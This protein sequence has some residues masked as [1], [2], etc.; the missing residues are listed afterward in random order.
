M[1]RALSAFHHL[2]QILRNALEANH[3][4]AEEE[5]FLLRA[6]TMDDRMLAERAAQ[7]TA[8]LKGCVSVLPP[9]SRH[10]DYD[11]IP[12]NISDGCL[13]HCAFCR[14]KSNRGFH[15]RSSQDILEQLTKLKD[16]YGRTFAIT[17]AFI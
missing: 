15:V 8:L 11:C 4:S 12:L 1:Q 14:V 3:W 17:T 7:L 2:S 9:D 5:T 16:F 10:V 6:I 13:Y